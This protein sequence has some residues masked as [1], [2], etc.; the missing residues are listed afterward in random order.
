[1]ST[2]LLISRPAP[3]KDESLLSFQLRLCEANGYGLYQLEELSRSFAQAPLRSFKKVDRVKI[4][5]A[6][7]KL[8]KHAAVLDMFD[9]WE[10]ADEYRAMFDYKRIK[11]CPRCFSDRP[12]IKRHW[13]LRSSLICDKHSCYMVDSCDRCG[14]KLSADSLISGKCI[15]C[16][17]HLCSIA[18]SDCNSTV[19]GGVNGAFVNGVYSSLDMESIFNQYREIDP[20]IL[21]IG[22]DAFKYWSK[23]RDAEINL[24]ADIRAQAELFVQDHLVGD[25]ALVRCIKECETFGL[26]NKVFLRYLAKEGFDKFNEH[27]KRI[28]LEYSGQ[29]KGMAISIGFLA[30]LYGLS[31][32]ELSHNLATKRYDFVEPARKG[33]TVDAS[34][35]P[36]LICGLA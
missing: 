16:G 20:Y 33:E 26:F 34:D 36:R 1:M 6:F 24:L 10:W 3:Y 8:S 21:M 5:R 28:L 32:E 19:F 9:P 17:Q 29:F 11:I 15:S 23:K 30:K 14:E 12:I 35:V 25:Q 22:D 2:K 18:A 13:H 4:K 31:K 27:V 7:S